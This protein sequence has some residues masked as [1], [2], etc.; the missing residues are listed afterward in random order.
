MSVQ[1]CS[2]LLVV[3][4]LL[5][6]GTAP[7]LG[8]SAQ[9]LNAEG[10]AALN[11]GR[12]EDAVKKL[13]G[14][15]RLQ[16][17]PMVLYNLGVA[18]MGLG[19][20][21][22]AVEAYESYVASADKK[23][24]A[25]N[26]RQVEGE[27]ERITDAAARF[28]LTVEPSHAEI[29][30]DGQRVTPYKGELWVSAGRHRISIGADGYESYQQELAVQPGRYNLEIKLR[31][32]SGPPPERAEAL[33][34][35]GEALAM[36]GDAAGALAKYEQAQAIYPS[37]HGYGRV[38]LAL[39]TSGQLALAEGA[40]LEALEAKRDPWLRAHRA[41]LNRA[42][43][44]LQK[45]LGTLDVK[46]TPAGAQVFVNGRMV[47]S[48]PLSGKVRAEAGTVIVKGAKDGYLDSVQELQL[49][50]R[51]KKKV[52][53]ALAEGVMPVGG[54][55]AGSA[56]AAAAAAAAQAALEQAEAEAA[57]A[58]AARLAAEQAA[59]EEAARLAAEEAAAAEAARLAAEQAEAE[60][61]RQEQARQADIE[62]EAEAQA[63]ADAGRAPL[64]QGFELKILG[65]GQFYLGDEK[66]PAPPEIATLPEVS[67]AVMFDIL[68]GGR[69]PWFLSYGAI[70][71]GGFNLSHDEMNFAVVNP[72]LYV[73]GHVQKE[74]R[75][76]WYDAWAGLAVRPVSMSAGMLKVQDPIDPDTIDMTQLDPDTTAGDVAANQAGVEYAALYQSVELDVQFGGTFWLTESIGLELALNV[77]FYFPTSTCLKQSGDTL[78]FD[79]GL[80]KY[81]SF[82]VQGGLAV[83]P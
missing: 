78:C 52:T 34:V 28:A 49:K 54:A 25:Q 26:V 24:E 58:E 67:S 46:G 15:Y 57:A 32:P 76:I 20:P 73:R 39:E 9:Q 1:S 7:A 5:L 41:E 6:L 48:L 12:Y 36:Q 27:I 33:I 66:P 30:I 38:G 21:D 70:L 69:F 22:K 19:R 43:A 40:I 17:V 45:Q 79:S 55:V 37:A 59:A 44:R 23:T 64:A 10:M 11:A 56:A 51:G 31:V 18:Y 8:Q 53:I 82:G 50:A 29:R 4:G 75:S 47:G 83:L 71:S 68:L 74:Q 81:T 77:A 42:K 61:L 62:A 2:R 72:G 16:P 63:Y 14:S 3:A 35:S 80:E 65:G 60:K 13:D